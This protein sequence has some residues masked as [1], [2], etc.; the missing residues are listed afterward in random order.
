MKKYSRVRLGIHKA[1][2]IPVR[3]A[4]KLVTFLEH[5]IFRIENRKRSKFC[6]KTVMMYYFYHFDGVICLSTY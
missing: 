3:V 2:N 5:I 1:P 6:I 4:F